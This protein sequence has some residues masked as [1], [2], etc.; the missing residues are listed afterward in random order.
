M[1]ANPSTAL[2]FLPPHA[3]EFLKSRM[4]SQSEITIQEM[5]NYLNN[6]SSIKRE[7]PVNDDDLILPSTTLSSLQKSLLIKD[8][9]NANKRVEQALSEPSLSP[10]PVLVQ[11]KQEP[12]PGMS[13]SPSPPLTKIRELPPASTVIAQAYSNQGYDSLAAQYSANSPLQYQNQPASEIYMVTTG[14]Y[15]GIP[16]YYT[17]Q[18]RHNLAAAT[19]ATSGSGYTD[20]TDTASFVDR[21]IRQAAGYKN[22]IQGLAVDL[23]SPD[24]GIGETA[25]T[26]RDNNSLPQVS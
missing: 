24:S 26:S 3:A 5:D 1:P 6:R 14:E 12:S 13:T 11:V 8:Y 21:Y 2:S 18:I 19:V 20:T 25:I 22:R 7:S 9:S 17:E 4:S 16:D 15:R 10:L 23:P